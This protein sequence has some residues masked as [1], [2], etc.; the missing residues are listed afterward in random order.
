MNGTIAYALSK[1][2]TNLVAV[3]ISSATVDNVNKTITFTLVADGSQHTIQF[4]QP[5]DGVSV[6]DLTV[7]ADN[8]LICIMSDNSEIDAGELPS[9]EP[10]LTEVLSPN[11]TMGSLKTSY[12]VGTSLEEIIRDML[13]EKIP[14]VTAMTLNPSALLYDEVSG[15][16]PTLTINATITKKTNDVAKVEFYINNTLVHTVSSG[17]T[18]GGSVPYI[19]NTVID[20]D[21]EIKVVTTDKESL[22]STA[23]KTITFIGNSY[24]GIV[25]PTLSDATEAIV[26][27]L[28]KSLKNTKKF[29]YSGINCD[30]NKI[31]YAY[32][33]ELGKLTS[34]MDKVNNFNYT[35][36]FQLSTKT[37]DGIEYYVYLLIDPTGADDVDLTFE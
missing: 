7:N 12:P 35:S 28:N 10:V 36:S 5:D 22:S 33:S 34:I 20:D 15:S 29:L 27:T 25:E 13:T 32:P 8:H 21:A 30:Y 31:V 19:Y 14:P 17:I 4:D 26:K 3:G 23:K 37:I 9:Y 11:V 6:V 18:S 24:Y 2:Y 16:I 1:K